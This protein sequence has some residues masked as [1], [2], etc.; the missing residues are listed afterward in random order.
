MYTTHNSCHDMLIIII[1]KNFFAISL[2][3]YSLSSNQM[4][5][6]IKRFKDFFQKVTNLEFASYECMRFDCC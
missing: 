3:N 4:I 6:E 5:K 1:T 2:L